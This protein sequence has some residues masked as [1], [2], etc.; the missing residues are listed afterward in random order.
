MSYNSGD[1][2]DGEWKLNRKCGYGIG[3]YANGDIYNGEWDN[4][5]KNGSGM[6]YVNGRCYKV[7]QW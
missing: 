5:M 3:N 6:F 4:N 7:F 1:K 2:Y